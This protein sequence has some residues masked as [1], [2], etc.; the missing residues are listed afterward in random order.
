M[1]G[2]LEAFTLDLD[3]S[4]PSSLDVITANRSGVAT[5]TDANGVI[6]SA[7]ANTVRV[8]HTQ[9]AELTP[10]V[11][12]N[13]GNTDFS[14]NW[15]HYLSNSSVQSETL[16]GQ[17]ILRW[18]TTG[19]TAQLK[20][21]INTEE[22]KNYTYSFFVRS[23]SNGG[24]NG[25]R[26][27]SQN[28]PINNHSVINLDSNFQKIVVTF[29]G[30]V[31]GGNVSIGLVELGTHTIDNVLEY[32][33]PQVVDGEIEYDFVANTTGSPKFI[34]G[35]TFGPRVPM[36]LVEPSATNLVTNTDF[37]SGWGLQSSTK[38]ETDITSPFQS[39]NALRVTASETYGRIQDYIGSSSVT[40]ISVYVKRDSTDSRVS[41]NSDGFGAVTFNLTQAG[42]SYHSLDGSPA[43]YD[44]KEHGDGWW[45]ISASFSS[46]DY[47]KLYP[48]IELGTRSVLFALPQV[49]AGSVATSYIPTA[50]GDAAARTRAADNLSIDPDSTNLVTHSDFSGGWQEYLINS[51]AGSGYSLN[52][53]RVITS[54]GANAAY[55][56]P[57]PTSNG[58][59]YTASI[60]ARRVSG[61]GGCNIIYLSSPTAKQSISLTSEFQKFTA[62][63]TGKSGGGNVNFGVDIVTSGDSIEIAMPQ[64]ELGSSPTGFI[65]TSGAPA[66]RTAFTDF[67]SSS[68]G[69][70]YA[71]FIFN[72]A[73]GANS[74]I[75][76]SADNQRFAY[77]NLGSSSPLLSYDGVNVLNYGR[78]AAGTLLRT[79]LSYNSNTMEGS[80]DGSAATMSNQTAPFPHTGNFLTASKLHIGSDTNGGKQLN[81]L[82]KR[83]IYW[84][85]HSDSL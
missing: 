58:A 31:G 67:F 9:G 30:K 14:S 64:V 84:P 48:D 24:G 85:Y 55:Y 39:Q 70:F 40:T 71:E 66:S 38:Q 25:F 47:F 36:I 61:S 74:L 10:T 41:I 60:W 81:G 28:S 17:P 11:F 35:A 75:Y 57:V 52:A 43:G 69:T 51:S 54:T 1:K 4:V 82:I 44:I 65:P 83:L 62:T 2:T 22:G 19:N 59:T 50:G 8:D 16:N 42:A 5:F 7:S 12:Q 6:Q 20:H 73:D 33:T 45:R 32:S 23:V 68:E 76:G 72:D 34:T 37:S 18:T 79:A 46:V 77:K 13:V 29:S 3:P 26:A 49:E 27:W 56:I 63:F 21:S 80:Q 15:S 78:L 53:S